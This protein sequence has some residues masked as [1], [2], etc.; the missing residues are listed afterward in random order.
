MNGL[1]S[2]EGALKVASLYGFNN[3][4]L[5]ET[6]NKKW[7]ELAPGSLFIDDLVSKK[8]QTN[9]VKKV[10]EFYFKDKD[11]DISTKWNLIDV[12]LL[13]YLKKNDL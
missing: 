8:E 12:S 2:H 4:K 6:F 13:M 9:I 11:I 3:E 7:V 5:V 1:N 10:R